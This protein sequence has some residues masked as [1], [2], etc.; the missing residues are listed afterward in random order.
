[1]TELVEIPL[2]QD[3]SIPLQTDGRQSGRLLRWPGRDSDRPPVDVSVDRR[4]ADLRPATR[5]VPDGFHPL[6]D[7]PHRVEVEFVIRRSADTLIVARIDAE[8][9]WPIVATGRNTAQ[10]AERA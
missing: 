9:T 10:G 3:G 6:T 8:P 7:R 4:L 5:A 2:D 1:V